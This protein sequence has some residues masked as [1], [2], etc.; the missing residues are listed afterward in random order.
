MQC[1]VLIA[2]LSVK[3]VNW[4]GYSQEVSLL[5]AVLSQRHFV[6]RIF[7]ALKCDT[8]RTKVFYFGIFRLLDPTDPTGFSKKKKKNRQVRP[9]QQFCEN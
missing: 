4:I 9:V 5:N 3:W 2:V 8:Y 1:N 7:T 6:T